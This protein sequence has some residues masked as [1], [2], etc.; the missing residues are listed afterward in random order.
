MNTFEKCKLLLFLSVDVVNSTKYKQQRKNKNEVQPW[1]PF[2]TN[3]YD[4]FPVIVEKSCNNNELKKDLCLTDKIDKVPEL[5]KSIG[6]ELVFTVKLDYSRKTAFY[7]LAFRDAVRQYNQQIKDRRNLKLKASAWLA[8]F[9]VNNAEISI[10]HKMGHIDYIGPSIDIGFRL[11]N[12]SSPRKFVVSVDLALMLSS[13]ISPLALFYDGNFILKGV[14]DDS[15][16][17]ITWIDTLNEGEHTV[18]QKLLNKSKADSD[19]LK[20]FCEKFINKTGEPLVHPF[21]LGDEFF[22]NM[23]ENYE[24]KYNK[25]IRTREYPFLDKTKEEV[26]EQKIAK[27]T[28][29][30]NKLKNDSKSLIEDIKILFKNKKE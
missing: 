30:D 4:N 19:N 22:G 23:P 17:P 28:P 16:Y 11:A 5:W 26:L 7:I 18:E 14:L 10:K 25:A 3:F 20:K 2:F 9:P 1:L 24:E 6:D 8:G 21:I 12:Y 15:Q 29:N 13:V 27:N